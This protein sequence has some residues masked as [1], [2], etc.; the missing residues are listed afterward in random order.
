MISIL[1]NPLVHILHVILYSI[2]LIFTIRIFWRSRNSFRKGIGFVILAVLGLMGIHILRDLDYY[3]LLQSPYFS[4]FPV[5]QYSGAL[6]AVAI[7]LLAVGFWYVQHC[8]YSITG[9]YPK[10]EVRRKK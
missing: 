9:E 7:A 6:E 5:S 10:K 4:I 2:V 8:I 3:S 1:Q